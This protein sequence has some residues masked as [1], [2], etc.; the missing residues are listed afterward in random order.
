M[1]K[2][3]FT[4]AVSAGEKKLSEDNWIQNFVTEQ[5]KK[6]SI[7]EDLTELSVKKLKDILSTLVLQENY[8]K[9]ARVRD[10]LSRRKK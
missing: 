2:A 9:A 5:S 10:E 3:G 6:T 1:K 4:A 8:E 7:N